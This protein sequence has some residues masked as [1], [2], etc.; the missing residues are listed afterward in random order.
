MET[1]NIKLIQYI[2]KKYN[3]ISGVKRLIASKKVFVIHLYIYILYLLC[4]C[5]YTHN[6]VCVYIYMYIHV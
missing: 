3:S 6:T 5:K 2:N 4:I 1:E